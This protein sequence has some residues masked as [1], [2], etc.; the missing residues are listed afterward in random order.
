MLLARVKLN[1]GQPHRALVVLEHFLQE[2]R[3]EGWEDL[4]VEGRE[5]TGI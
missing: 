4:S 2:V 5:Y 3:W 1:L